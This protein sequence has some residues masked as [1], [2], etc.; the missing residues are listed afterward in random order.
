MPYTKHIN[1]RNNPRQTIMTKETFIEIYCEVIHPVPTLTEAI[2][3]WTEFEKYGMNKT[4]TRSKL[5][6]MIK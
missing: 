2:A 5:T 6:K 4:L 1:Q 3:V